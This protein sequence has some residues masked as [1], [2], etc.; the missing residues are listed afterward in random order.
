MLT[1]LAMMMLTLLSVRM[2]TALLRTQDTMQNSKFGL[3]AISLA[4]SVIE[5]ANKLAFDE[6][7]TEN[8]ITSTGDLT[9]ISYLGKDAGETKP[10][11][12][13]DFDDYNNYQHD[14]TTLASA[15]Y[16]ISCK[17]SYVNALTPNVDANSPT[18]N[19]KLTV[20][21][22]SISMQDTIKINTIFSYWYFR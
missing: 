18:F 16:H 10:S 15:A 5:N 3:A 11:Q 20:S 9:P 21:V 7:S 12:Y 17:V 6:A 2:N 1:L 8:S 4:T 13:D 14:E 22:S 19:K